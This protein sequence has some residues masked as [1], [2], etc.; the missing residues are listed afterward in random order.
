MRVALCVIAVLLGSVSLGYAQNSNDKVDSRWKKFEIPTINPD[1]DFMNRFSVNES[2]IW[3]TPDPSNLN[4]AR[5]SWSEG[6]RPF[7]LTI[8]RPLY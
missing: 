4:E 1:I 3:P 7:G 6:D 2:Q 8:S 5:R